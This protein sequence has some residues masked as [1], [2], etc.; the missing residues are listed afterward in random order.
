MKTITLFDNFNARHSTQEEVAETFVSNIDFFNIAKNNHTFVLG[1]RGCGKTTMFKMLTTAALNNWKPKTDIEITLKNNIPFVAIY[2]P[3]DELWKDQL[4]S[5]TKTLTNEPEL[6]SFIAN[7]LNCTN[8]FTNFCQ[9]IRNHIAHLE[10]QNKQ[11]K[12]FVFT[13]ELIKIWRLDGSAASFASIKLALGERRSKLIE[14]L[15]KFNFDR[16]FLRKTNIE[17]EDYYYADFL[18]AIKNA[19]NAFE[20]IYN[21]ENEIKWALCFDELE[22]V[23]KDF[24]ES[25]L[26]KLRIAPANIVFKLSSSPLTDFNDNIA[27]VFH[28][29]EVVKMWPFSHTEEKRY[30]IFCEE[31][32]RERIMSYR[33][34]KGIT[35]Q[36]PIDFSSVFGTLDYS[37]NAL[38]EFGFNID[39]TVADFEPNSLSWNVFKELATYDGDLRK[40]MTSRGID[41]NN[42]VPLT[43]LNADTFLRKTKEIAINRLLF[44]KYKNDKYYAPKG[45]KEYPIYHGR[46]T[47]FK[48]CEGN[49]RFIMNII[50]DIF[51]KTGRYADLTNLY[52]KPE[53]QANVVKSVSSRFSAMLNTYPTSVPF[54]GRY[55]D[56]DWLIEKIGQYFDNQINK[57]AFKI[58]P[59][60][61]FFFDPLNTPKTIVDL[62]NIGVS[63]GAF[64]KLDK[65]IDDLSKSNESRFRLSYLLHPQFKLPLRLYSSVKLNNILTKNIHTQQLKIDG[66]GN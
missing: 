65:S 18:V 58:N 56:L 17:F 31:I 5:L 59:A 3:S 34:K 57:G 50:N 36:E 48:V 12:E 21:D 8:I 49:P 40:E 16:K 29:Y 38:K 61:S 25:I 42:P 14:K 53:E 44:S 20:N 33:Q 15:T 1:P 45:K 43:K 54:S 64:V 24:I 9:S 7:A 23:S 63:L 32:A 60:N 19:M 6:S 27:Q 62:V 66:N 22:L 41:P 28:D 26:K 47:V 46:E 55:V 10:V 11:E 13:N 51:I 37:I 2:I 35:E 52:F 30:S 4:K 39:N